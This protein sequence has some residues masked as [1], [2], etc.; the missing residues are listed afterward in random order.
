MNYRLYEKKLASK[1][2]SARWKGDARVRRLLDKWK[3]STRA[4]INVNY[5]KLDKAALVS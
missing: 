1:E 2:R 4:F 3:L 5:Q